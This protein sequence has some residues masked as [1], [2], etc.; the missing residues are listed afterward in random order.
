MPS[1][2]QLGH[3]IRDWFRKS[4]ANEV[5][6]ASPYDRFIALWI[7]FNAWG[8]N[9]YGTDQD[10]AM[11]D[12]AVT[13][14]ELQSHFQELCRDKVFRQLT[15]ELQAYCPVWD[16]RPGHTRKSKTVA[17]PH[18]L[19]EVLRVI[20]Q[21]RCNLF[22]GSKAVDD[23]RDSQLVYLSYSILSRLMGLILEG[24]P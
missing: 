17:N 23:D 15:A 7:S 24:N 1:P 6:L 9:R 13:D 22:H 5:V 21:V 18:D 19:G 14:G 11:I 16:M 3:I 2:E 4:Q 10:R 8:T 20:Y 12:H